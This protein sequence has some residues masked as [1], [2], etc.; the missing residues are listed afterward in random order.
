MSGEVVH[1]AAK[2]DPTGPAPRVRYKDV[3]EQVRLV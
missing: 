2:R 3:F 1:A